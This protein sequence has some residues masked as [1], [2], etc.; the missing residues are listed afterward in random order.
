M[1]RRDRR[2]PLLS[3]LDRLGRGRR[4]ASPR[5]VGGDERRGDSTV[6]V[7]LGRGCVALEGT[8][9]GPVYLAPLQVG[10]L[11]AALKAAAVRAASAEPGISEPARRS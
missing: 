4:A 7:S 1:S 11:R 2:M 5:G 3:I 6:I 8:A 9:F 10:R